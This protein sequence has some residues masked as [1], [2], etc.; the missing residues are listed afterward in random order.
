MLPGRRTRSRDQHRGTSSAATHHSS[1]SNQRHTQRSSAAAC[2]I[3][4]TPSAPPVVA[5]HATA[6]SVT[7]SGPPVSSN[8][9]NWLGQM[10]V[11]S[12]NRRPL[13]L[14]QMP[15]ILLRI[16]HYCALDP[17][18]TAEEILPSMRHRSCACK[19]PD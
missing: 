19:S 2:P 3:S 14:Q 15:S 1:A 11:S 17:E 8:H 9:L 6:I 12:Q 18:R 7:P 5:G 16:V 4:V 10:Q 13:F